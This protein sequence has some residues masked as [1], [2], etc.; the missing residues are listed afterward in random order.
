MHEAPGPAV[1]TPLL[2]RRNIRLG[3]V[4]QDLN[5]SLSWF[6]AERSN[7]KLPCSITGSKETVLVCSQTVIERYLPTHSNVWFAALWTKPH[8]QAAASRSC[9]ELKQKLLHSKNSAETESRPVN[10]GGTGGSEEQQGVPSLI[11]APMEEKKTILQCVLCW[12][13]WQ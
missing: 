2:L 6:Q 11:P 3:V 8:W 9:L 12:H 10:P 1:S 5:I 13:T 4:S 7:Y